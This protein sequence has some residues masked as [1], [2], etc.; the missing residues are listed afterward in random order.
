MKDLNR[1][2][3]P[4]ATK[5]HLDSDP[6]GKDVDQKVYRSM[7]GSLLYLCAFRPHIVLAVQ[8]IKLLL[9]KAT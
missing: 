1:A 8:G 6:N 5:C 3:T 2:P 7:I 4:M 9:K